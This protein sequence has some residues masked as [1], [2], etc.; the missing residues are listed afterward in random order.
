MIS[1]LLFQEIHLILQVLARTLLLRQEKTPLPKKLPSSKTGK[2][3]LLPRSHHLP[4]QERVFLSRSLHLPLCQVRIDVLESTFLFTDE[5]F[6][7]YFLHLLGTP[8]DSSSS[9]KN[10]PPET[11]KDAP[12]P[13]KPP[14]SKT[15]KD[16]P[17]SK[18]PSPPKT[19][20]S[21]PLK[22]PPPP[23]VSGTELVY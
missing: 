20:K 11:G 2:I 12:L 14:S 3:Y 8:P 15:G 6:Q 9:C 21:L 22:K 16:L 10:P 5:P 18:K 17:P 7:R 19:G 23:I 1:D 4:R 13:R